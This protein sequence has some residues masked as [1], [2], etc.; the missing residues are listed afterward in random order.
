[1][2]FG[3]CNLT[4][5]VHSKGPVIWFIT[6][7]VYGGWCFGFPVSDVEV[8]LWKAVVTPHLFVGE[9]VLFQELLF[10]QSERNLL[11]Y[12]FLCDGLVTILEISVFGFLQK[13]ASNGLS[14]VVALGMSLMFSIMFASISL[15][16]AWVHLG[17]ISSTASLR[18]IV[19]ISLSTM[20]VPQWSPAG[21]SISLKFLFSRY[22]SNS[23]VLNACAWSHRVDL[24]IPCTLQ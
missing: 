23:L 18:F 6:F 8:V 7:N 4:W 2:N 24:G 11:H 3:R 14:C 15:S 16:V 17:S 13:C 10:K 5:W 1:M 20:P 12:K 9:F 21:A 22:I 19:W